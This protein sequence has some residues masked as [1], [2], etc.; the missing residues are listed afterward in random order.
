M[1][2][3]DAKAHADFLCILIQADKAPVLFC[4]IYCAPDKKNLNDQCE[5]LM[6]MG[7]HNAA[8]SK[9]DIVLVQASAAS[10]LSRCARPSFERSAAPCRWRLSSG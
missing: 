7:K 5:F 10:S 2:M 6:M 4:S 1:R 8:T 9:S 3:Y